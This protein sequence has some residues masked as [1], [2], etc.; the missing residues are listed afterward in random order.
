M[1]TIYKNPKN[2]PRTWINYKGFYQIQFGWFGFKCYTDKVGD[3]I[4]KGFNLG[5]I[6]LEKLR[7]KLYD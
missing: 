2:H 6:K 1:I 4:I 5:F 3:F 7:Y